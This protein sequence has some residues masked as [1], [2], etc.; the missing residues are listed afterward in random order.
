[1]NL[2]RPFLWLRSRVFMV[3][4]CFL[5]AISCGVI[6]FR[7]GY[8]IVEG[9]IVQD[10]SGVYCAHIKNERYPAD[11]FTIMEPDWNINVSTGIEHGLELDMWKMYGKAPDSTNAVEP[12]L[13][14]VMIVSIIFSFFITAQNPPGFARAASDRDAAADRRRIL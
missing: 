14:F 10:L 7:T 12:V 8:P 3:L 2:H 6:C 4:P 13:F 11:V 5:Q 9:V 1:M